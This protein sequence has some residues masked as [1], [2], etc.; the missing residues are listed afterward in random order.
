MRKHKSV[1]WQAVGSVDKR[2][3]C[4]AAQLVSDSDGSSSGR[5]RGGSRVGASPNRPSDGHVAVSLSLRACLLLSGLWQ[6]IALLARTHRQAPASTHTQRQTL[7]QTRIHAWHTPTCA[8]FLHKQRT[9]AL[10]AHTAYALYGLLFIFSSL[11]SGQCRRLP[12]NSHAQHKVRIGGRARVC[13]CVWTQG[14]GRHSRAF[15]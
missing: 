11:L 4:P 8:S 2:Q 10:W 13:V 12:I 7:T 9:P 3:R 1:G 6:A 15:N 5:G 14:R